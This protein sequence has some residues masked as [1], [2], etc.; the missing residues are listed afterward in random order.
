MS[1]VSEL[2]QQIWEE[3]SSICS[4]AVKPSIDTG[5]VSSVK[6]LFGAKKDRG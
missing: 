4:K 1:I 3:R 5:I 2:E 6:V